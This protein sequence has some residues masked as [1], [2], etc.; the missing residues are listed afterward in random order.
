MAGEH[1]V[2]PIGV[3]LASISA[4]LDT[5]L[6]ALGKTLQRISERLDALEKQQ[7]AGPPERN[8]KST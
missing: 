5:K 7:S 1:N 6:A 3:T 8:R 4:L 2:T